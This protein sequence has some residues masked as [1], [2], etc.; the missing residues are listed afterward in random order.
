MSYHSIKEWIT[1]AEQKNL[2]LWEVVLQDDMAERAV[3]KEESIKAM[4]G[5]WQAMLS[6][7]E[8]YD[9]TLRSN[10]GLVGT[11]G[12]KLEDYGKKGDTLCG[13]FINKVMTQAVQVSESNAC[14]KR[15]VAAPTAGSCGV[16]PAVFVT[17]YKEKKATEEQIIEALYIA[18]GIGKVV[19]ERASIAGA[20]GGCQAEVGTAS[21]MTAGALA[22]LKGGNPKQVSDAAAIALK[23]LL[24]LAC[25]PVAGLVEVPCVK[26]NVIG[27]INAVAAADMVLA[28]I[29]SVIPADDVIDAMGQIGRE[30]S[31]KIKETALGGLAA[32]P[33]GQEIAERVLQKS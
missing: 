21:A 7:A 8:Q 24:G 28:G 27:A 2:N 11:D 9:G 1:A 17:L 15:I 31:Y 18:S 16:M 23:N 22:G 5:I 19:A 14:M 20:S 12:Q 3:S 30:M 25:D 6:S 26:R 29:G 4:K 33:T 13:D 32:T 10:S